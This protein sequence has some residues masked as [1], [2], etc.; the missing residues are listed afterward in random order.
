VVSGKKAF[1]LELVYSAVAEINEQLVPQEHVHP[2][3]MI[4]VPRRSRGRWRGG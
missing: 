3:L 2:I 1:I 4:E